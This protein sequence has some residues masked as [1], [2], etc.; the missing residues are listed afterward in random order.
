M[1]FNILFDVSDF[2]ETDFTFFLLVI[3]LS[4]FQHLILKYIN[5]FI[6]LSNNVC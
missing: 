4:L 2:L 3:S 5:C 6:L 1:Q